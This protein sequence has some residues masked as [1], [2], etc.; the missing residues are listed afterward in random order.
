MAA[1]DF[2]SRPWRWRAFQSEYGSR[3]FVTA[4]HREML[5]E[6]MYHAL[7][8]CKL[9]ERWERYWESRFA[10]QPSQIRGTPL[11]V[12]LLLNSALCYYLIFN[13]Q[14]LF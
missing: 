2:R 11:A 10:G 7:R 6:V 4:Q 5:D 9:S 3:I 14:A 8:C 1:L 12:G 13:H